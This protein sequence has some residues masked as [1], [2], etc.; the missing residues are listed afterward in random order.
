M[1]A[2]VEFG[3]A[4][5]AAGRV[6]PRERVREWLLDMAAGGDAPCRSLTSRIEGRLDG[7]GPRGLGAVRAHLHPLNPVAA[8][9][10]AQ[11][12]LLA[13]D[14]LSLFPAHGR[15]GLEPGTRELVAVRPYVLVYEVK[16]AEVVILAAWHGAQERRAGRLADAHEHRAG[17]DLADQPQHER[18]RPYRRHARRV[19]PHEPEQPPAEHQ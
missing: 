8:R 12:L 1:R 16:G 14:G 3:R 6:V 15:G 5:A 13:G 11:A 7:R 19:Q 10:I 17:V 18:H 9:K 2:A 4:D